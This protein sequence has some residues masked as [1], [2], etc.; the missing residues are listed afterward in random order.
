MMHRILAR[1]N[2]LVDGLN[3]SLP[4]EEMDRLSVSGRADEIKEAFDTDLQG[5]G[6]KCYR[7]TTN[8][9]TWQ[10]QYRDNSGSTSYY[11]NVWYEPYEG[12]KFHAM[13][14]SPQNID[15]TFAE[16]SREMRALRET[17]ISDLQ[18]ILNRDRRDTMSDPTRPR[19]RQRTDDPMLMMDSRIRTAYK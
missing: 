15:D 1:L 13:H 9:V 14:F 12:G 7:Q 10:Y 3:D 4:F 11:V 8:E 17:L 5:L 18:R 6:F 19:A 16:N 2:S